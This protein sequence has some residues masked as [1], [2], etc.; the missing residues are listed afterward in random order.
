MIDM[1]VA[2]VVAAL[3]ACGGAAAAADATEKKFNVLELRCQPIVRLSTNEIVGCEALVRWC[4]PER[5]L[6]MPETFIGIAEETRWIVAI[7]RWVLRE[8]CATA[9]RMRA[10]IPDFRVSINMSSRDLRE[11]DLPDVVATALSDY[12]LPARA[13]RRDHGDRRARRERAAGAATPLHAERQQ[14]RSQGRSVSA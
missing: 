12:D 3:A 5:G 2:D 7:D 10:T 14:S 6:I 11:P 8:A 9:H 13:H 4:H 1:P